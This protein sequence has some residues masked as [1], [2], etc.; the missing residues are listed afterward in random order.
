MPPNPKRKRE[1]SRNLPYQSGVNR[2]IPLT[3]EELAKRAAV[4][5]AQQVIGGMKFYLEII[6]PQAKF[7]WN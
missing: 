2:P 3:P 1:D 7:R 5:D 6:M 4:R